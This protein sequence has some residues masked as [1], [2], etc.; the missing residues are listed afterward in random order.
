MKVSDTQDE[1]SW[2][3]CQGK[4]SKS[5]KQS[6]NRDDESSNSDLTLPPPPFTVHPR[7]SYLGFSGKVRN[8]IYKH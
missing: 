4:A 2:K 7:P 3:K 6:P 8:I 1:V 5:K